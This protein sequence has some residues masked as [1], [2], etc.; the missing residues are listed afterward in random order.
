MEELCAMRV[1][2]LIPEREKGKREVFSCRVCSVMIFSTLKE[3][4]GRQEGVNFEYRVLT[5]QGTSYSG[6]HGTPRAYAFLNKTV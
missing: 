5:H 6:G 4:A 3:P 2:A 1:T